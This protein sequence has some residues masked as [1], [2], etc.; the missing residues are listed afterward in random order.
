MQNNFYALA[1]KNTSSVI[2]LIIIS[3]LINKLFQHEWCNKMYNIK[4]KGTVTGI[5]Y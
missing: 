5:R 3:Q 1:P 4:I 2:G